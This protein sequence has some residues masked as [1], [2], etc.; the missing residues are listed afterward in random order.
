MEP[1]VWEHNG[2]FYIEGHDDIPFNSRTAAE[3]YYT[4]MF[5]NEAKSKKFWHWRNH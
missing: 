4:I 2:L 3:H 5:E 1:Q